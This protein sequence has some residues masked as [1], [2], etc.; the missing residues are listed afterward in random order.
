MPY[1]SEMDA[2]ESVLRTYF[3]R[4]YSFCQSDCTL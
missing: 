3:S 1:L 2:I 4:H